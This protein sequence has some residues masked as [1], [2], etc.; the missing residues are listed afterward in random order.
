V[1]HTFTTDDPR[2]DVVVGPGEERTVTLTAGGQVTFSCRF[3][4][5]DGMKGA[6]CPPGERCDVPAFP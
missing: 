6:I 1:S 3:H 4:E 2:T 5:S